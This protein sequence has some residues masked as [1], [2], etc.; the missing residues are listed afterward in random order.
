MSLGAEPGRED[1]EALIRDEFSSYS[2]SPDYSGLS[3]EDLILELVA[4]ESPARDLVFQIIDEPSRDTYSIYEQAVQMVRNPSVHALQ[5]LRRRGAKDSDLRFVVKTRITLN[6]I[7]VELRKRFEP[8]PVGRAIYKAWIERPDAL[9]DLLKA[10]HV[11][12]ITSY[13][14]NKESSEDLQSI[15]SLTP[16]RRYREIYDR[17]AESLGL[18]E[19]I[20]LPQVGHHRLVLE[21][22]QRHEVS[23]SLSLILPLFRGDAEKLPQPVRQ[24]LREE[25][26]KWK[27]DKRDASEVS[28]YEEGETDESGRPLVE[29]IPGHYPDPEESAISNLEAASMMTLAEKRYGEKGRL[30]L[31]ALSEDMTFAEAATLAGISRQTA[32]RYVRELRRH[33]R[34]RLR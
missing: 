13:R 8:F 23:A 32:H 29:R 28:T 34:G 14:E 31:Q 4:T 11:D 17:V 10:L 25:F 6:D 19:K 21:T 20:D 26:R 33:R 12:R 24:A 5:L 16:W 3:N 22:L 9:A 27:A 7:Y 30:F 1:F 2:G 15:A 18:P